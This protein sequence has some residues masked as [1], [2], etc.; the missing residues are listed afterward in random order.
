MPEYWPLVKTRFRGKPRIVKD[1]KS[2]CCYQ[3]AN[4]FVHYVSCLEDLRQGKSGGSPVSKAARAQGK[5]KTCSSRRLRKLYCSCD[6][7]LVLQQNACVAA[8]LYADLEVVQVRGVFSHLFDVRPNP[9]QAE[10]ARSARPQ[11][12]G[13]NSTS[14]LSNPFDDSREPPRNVP[15]RFRGVNWYCRDWLG[16]LFLTGPA[17]DSAAFIAALESAA[18]PKI[19]LRALARGRPS[20]IQRRSNVFSLD[21]YHE[22]SFIKL[23]NRLPTS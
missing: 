14:L 5:S 10:E 22:R 18:P 19:Y 16:A 12:A 8:V 1:L 7:A 21:S 11:S 15:R 2:H 6:A 20:D 4:V 23:W 9:W 17:S 3:T 13:C